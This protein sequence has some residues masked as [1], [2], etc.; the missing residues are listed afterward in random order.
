MVRMFLEMCTMQASLLGTL[1][2]LNMEEPWMMLDLGLADVQGSAHCIPGR[3]SLA[4]SGSAPLSPECASKGT[5]GKP[6]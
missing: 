3:G 2:G 4:T 6:W 1:L 5:V